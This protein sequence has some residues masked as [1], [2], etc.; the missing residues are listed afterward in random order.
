MMDSPL[1]K[2]D[3][4]GG[5]DIEANE[6]IGVDRDINADMKHISAATRSWLYMI[7]SKL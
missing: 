1:L 2:V 7:D 6:S 3:G 4:G 5:V